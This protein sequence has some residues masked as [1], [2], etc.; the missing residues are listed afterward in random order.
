MQTYRTNDLA[1]AAGLHTN[2]IRLYEGIGFLSPAARAENGYRIFDERHLLQLDICR[3]VFRCQWLGREL[4]AASLQVIRAMAA[5]ELPKAAKLARRYHDMI[6]AEYELAKSTAR[7]LADWSRNRAD[8]SSTYLALNRAEAAKAI[9]VT[10]ETLRTWERSGLVVVPRVGPNRKRVYG[11]TEILRLRIIHML[12]RSKY[13]LSAILRALTE[14]DKGNAAGVIRALNTPKADLV[15]GSP[16][17]WVGDRWLS[18]LS[19]TLESA[20]EILSLIR[21]AKKI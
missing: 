19:Q 14:H 15:E 9:E 8:H 13:S 2:T 21:K 11:Q 1:K 4:R 7:V 12:R 16:W 17:I 20:E 5:W 18:A 10:E 3:S 6:S